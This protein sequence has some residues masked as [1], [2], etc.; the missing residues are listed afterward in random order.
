MED[1]KITG[2]V[3]DKLWL[4]N[5]IS[6][7]KR[8]EDKAVVKKKDKQVTNMKYIDLKEETIL[9]KDRYSFG[10]NISKTSEGRKIIEACIASLLLVVH[11]T[12]SG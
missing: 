4:L 6:E 9:D 10:G 8:V 2:K 1:T 7:T 12:S 11:N 5:S 3:S